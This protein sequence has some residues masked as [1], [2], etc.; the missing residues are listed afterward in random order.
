MQ[1]PE[2]VQRLVFIGPL[3]AVV[4]LLI[5]VRF[6]WRMALYVWL[7][8]TFVQ[9]SLTFSLARGSL[10]LAELPRFLLYF[11][12][13][14]LFPLGLWSAVVSVLAWLAAVRWQR[15][16]ALEGAQ[17]IGVCS[18]AGALAGLVFSFICAFLLNLFR[19]QIPGGANLN[20]L[21]FSWELGGLVAGA[22]DGAIVAVFLP[23]NSPTVEQGGNSI[24]AVHRQ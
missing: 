19:N 12:P 24:L 9:E 18:V 16:L 23:S 7:A 13:F 1:S 17:K 20:Q 8:G 3:V 6:P 10:A 14:A 4:L 15:L 2:I 11:Y 5:L 21:W 22:I